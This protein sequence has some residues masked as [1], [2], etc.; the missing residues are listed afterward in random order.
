[1]LECT[2]MYIQLLRKELVIRLFASQVLV[3]LGILL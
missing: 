1:V 2:V 3:L